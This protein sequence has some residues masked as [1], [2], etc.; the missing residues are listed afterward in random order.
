MGVSRMLYCSSVTHECGFHVTIKFSFYLPLT[1]LATLS[2]PYDQSR[3]FKLI[4]SPI[5]KPGNYLPSMLYIYL[6]YF[7]IYIRNAEA[8]LAWQEMKDITEGVVR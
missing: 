2:Q 1:T 4:L 3:N 6:I 8:D 7:S 5:F